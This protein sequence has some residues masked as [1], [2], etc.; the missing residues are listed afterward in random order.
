MP[1]FHFH[2][3]DDQRQWG[4]HVFDFYLNSG[5]AEIQ[6]LKSLHLDMIDNEAFYQADLA[7]EAAAAITQLEQSR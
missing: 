2:F 3:I 1:G 4:G 5:V 6:V 7:T